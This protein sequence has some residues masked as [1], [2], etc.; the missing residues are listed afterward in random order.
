MKPRTAY[1]RTAGKLLNGLKEANMG[2]KTESVPSA[3]GTVINDGPV[4]KNAQR[5]SDEAQNDEAKNNQEKG[6]MLK[7]INVNRINY[8]GRHNAFT[9]LVEWK[10]NTIWF[11]VRKGI[12]RLP[13]GK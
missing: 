10:T 13:M 2:T 6:N 8:D 3:Q 5:A 1:A 4:R 9:D 7:L 11:S 12:L